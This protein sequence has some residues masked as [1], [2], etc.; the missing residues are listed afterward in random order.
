M[1]L[2]IDVN[3]KNIQSTFFSGCMFQKFINVHIPDLSPCVLASLGVDMSCNKPAFMF[4]GLNF[5]A[6]FLDMGMTCS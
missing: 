6:L 1:N 5:V 2:K 4:I 3:N